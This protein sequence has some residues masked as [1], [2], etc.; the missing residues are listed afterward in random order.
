MRIKVQWFTEWVEFSLERGWVGWMNSARV[1]DWG[2]IGTE[3][4]TETEAGW[5]RTS[6]G[7]SKGSPSLQSPVGIDDYTSS[8]TC[9]FPHELSVCFSTL[10]GPQSQVSKGIKGQEPPWHSGSGVPASANLPLSVFPQ[11][12]PMPIPRP[13]SPVPNPPPIGESGQTQ[14]GWGIFPASY[15][16]LPAY[17]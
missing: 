16:G 6:L 9:I 12:Q 14:E 4:I 3:A 11:S 17:P 1:M 15:P 10:E 8:T 7:S 5:P 13:I 2:Q